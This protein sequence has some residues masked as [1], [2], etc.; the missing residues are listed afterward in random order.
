MV[1]SL[2]LPSEAY[3]PFSY[4]GLVVDFNGIDIEHSHVYIQTFYHNYID[5]LV[6]SH[7][8]NE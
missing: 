3:K 2:Q 6:I 1:G 7:F 8:F 5:S 4:L